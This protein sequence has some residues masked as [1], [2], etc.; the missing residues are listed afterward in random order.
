MFFLFYFFGNKLTHQ[1]MSLSV[2]NQAFIALEREALNLDAVFYWAV[3][4]LITFINDHSRNPS[5]VHTFY[6]L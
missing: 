5:V 4:L 2:V 1:Q 3:I 6:I